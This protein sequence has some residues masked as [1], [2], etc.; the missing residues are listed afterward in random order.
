MTTETLEKSNKLLAKINELENAKSV[1]R[2]YSIVLQFAST[3]ILNEEVEE[4]ENIVSGAW[5]EFT[6]AKLLQLKEEFAAL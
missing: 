6:S 1:E 4:F 2:S 3:A 5:D